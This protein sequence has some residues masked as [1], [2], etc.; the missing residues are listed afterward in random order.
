MARVSVKVQDLLNNYPPEYTY[1]VKKE[2][3][4][5]AAYHHRHQHGTVK[6]SR[7][8]FADSR[9]EPLF[10]QQMPMKV[11]V[12]NDFFR[13]HEVDDEKTRVF[14]LNFADSQLF[15]FYDGYMFAQD[16]I[17]TLEHPLLGSVME[18]I[19][20]NETETLVALT[21]QKGLPTP[22]I[23]EHVP[24]WIQ[25]QTNP[26]LPDGRRAN[27]YGRRLRLSTPEER[28]QGFSVLQ[29]EKK[30]NIIA[31]AAPCGGHGLYTVKQLEYLLKCAFSA[32][33]GATRVT[34]ASKHEFCTIHTGKWGCGAFG[35]NEELIHLVQLIAASSVGVTNIVF[36]A[37]N[38]AALVKAFEKFR[39][40]KDAWSIS[41]LTEYLVSQKYQ[42]SDEDGN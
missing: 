8:Q 10:F 39:E 11:L 5:R 25:I 37:V 21:E 18:Y 19:D 3:Y 38:H 16:E 31:M 28:A 41:Q 42:W 34:A 26:V 20:R 17:Q 29:S 12:R 23:V 33:A 4:D 27:L 1:H 40:W 22:Y 14:W 9:K 15:G 2:W 32:F 30:N 7:W 35:N 13:Y 36:H 6:I 24:Y